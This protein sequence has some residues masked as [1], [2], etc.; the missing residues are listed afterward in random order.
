VL[1]LVLGQGGRLVASGLG[2]GLLVT[3][4]TSSLFSR[5]LFG[6]SATSPVALAL[7]ALGLAA[8]AGTACLVPALRAAR[9]TPLA[10]L[11]K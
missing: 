3:V 11:R 1:R 8:V 2:L 10:A 7:V 4:W 9:V 5:L 6:V